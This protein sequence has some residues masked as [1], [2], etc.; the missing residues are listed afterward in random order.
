MSRL[1][2]KPIMIPSGVTVNQENDWWVFRGPK[3]ELKQNLP[4][5]I[6]ITKTETENGLMVKLSKSA[7]P[8]QKWPRAMLGTAAALVQNALK[9]V[10]EGFEKKLELEGVGY[11]VQPD[12]KDLVLFLGF[13]HPV[14]FLA[15]EGI[16]F[17]VEKNIITVRGIDKAKVGKAAAELRSQKPPEPYKGK[18]IHYI[19]EVIKRK[20]GKKATS[21]A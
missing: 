8:K 3:G 5:I 20:A 6:S 17:S 14:R 2:R 9:G 16:T 1:A 7:S 18:G 12:G 13:S 21:S 19:G 11:K 15:P 10:A 4:N